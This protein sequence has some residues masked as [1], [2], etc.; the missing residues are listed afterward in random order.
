MQETLTLGEGKRE[1]MFKDSLAHTFQLDF[2]FSSFACQ[3]R[4]CR[5]SLLF[6]FIWNNSSVVVG[7]LNAHLSL[8]HSHSR[9]LVEN[10]PLIK[11]LRHW[12][13]CVDSGSSCSVVVPLCVSIFL[14]RLQASRDLLAGREKGMI[15]HQVHCVQCSTRMWAAEEEE[16]SERCMRKEFSY[17]DGPWT[18]S[19][20]WAK[21]FFSCDCSSHRDSV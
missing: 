1:K 2:T 3:H 12:M 15:D 7:S 4:Y 10:F 14:K 19:R 16:V 5:F 9:L 6:L 21:I 11:L 13:L 18:S 8:F 17:V 20:A